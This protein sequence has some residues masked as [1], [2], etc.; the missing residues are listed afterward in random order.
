MQVRGLPRHVIRDAMA[1]WRPIAA[2]RSEAATRRD[3]LAG[4]EAQTL[5]G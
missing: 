3:A 2:R 1:A 5:R 4:G